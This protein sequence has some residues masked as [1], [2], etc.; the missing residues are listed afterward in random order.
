MLPD[1]YA[2]HRSFEPA[3]PAEFRMDRHYLL[4]AREGTMRLEAAGRRWTLP[5]A[6][7]ALIAAGEPVTVT[8]LTRLISASVLFAPGFAEAPPS[9]LSVFEMTPLA[10]ELIAECRHHGPDEGPLD[11]YTRQLF[12]VL[13]TV[14]ARLSLRPTFCVMPVPA[15][16]ALSQALDLTEARHAVAPTF[17]EIARDSGISPRALARR[18]SDELGMTWSQALRR[19]RMIHA[20]ETLAGSDTSI[21]EIAM[22]VGYTSLSA[23]NVAFRDFTGRTPSGFRAS[24]KA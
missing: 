22:S 9:P 24:L 23:F 1:A 13:A 10:R 6:R 3:G 14:A 16:R 21:T 4:Y 17:D 2:F 11:P 20:V 8:I 12:A 7:A 19:I 5:P 18:F 15:T